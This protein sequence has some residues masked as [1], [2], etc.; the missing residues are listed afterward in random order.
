[1][2]ISITMGAP[3]GIHS[4]SNIVPKQQRACL[5]IDNVAVRLRGNTDQSSQGLEEAGHA[6]QLDPA[7]CASGNIFFDF[8]LRW[9]W[10]L[11]PAQH[12]ASHCTL[13]GLSCH[14]DQDQV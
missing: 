2:A 11:Q 12:F 5:L 8:V 9:P 7:A 4:Q 3:S 6:T 14:V 13:L 10:K 1:M